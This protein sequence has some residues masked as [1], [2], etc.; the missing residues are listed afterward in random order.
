MSHKSNSSLGHKLI[1]ICHLR[2]FQ[3]KERAKYKIQNLCPMQL[4]MYMYV[5]TK[6][7]CSNHCLQI[8]SLQDSDLR[9]ALLLE[10]A[11]HCYINMEIPKVRKYAFHMILAGHRYSKSGQRKHAIRSYSQALQVYKGKNW[12]LAEVTV[13]SLCTC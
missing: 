10:Q 6:E 5:S 12:A 4:Y 7:I 9:S 11:A 8:L 3:F 13:L 1:N 2:M